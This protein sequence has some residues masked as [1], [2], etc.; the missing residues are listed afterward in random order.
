V[1]R[2]DTGA[3]GAAIGFSVALIG[4][5]NVWL[6]DGRG[7]AVPTAIGVAIGASALAALLRTAALAPSALLG[8][9]LFALCRFGLLDRARRPRSLRV[10]IAFAFGL[11]HGFGLTAPLA[12]LDLPSDRLAAALLGYNVGVA[13]GQLGWVVL[14]AATLYATTRWRGRRSTRTIVEIGSTA[15]FATGVFWFVRRAFG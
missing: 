11:V 13:I 7:R 6:I 12:A 5:E 9:G 14:L 2:P 10:A 15:L 3:V 4:A 8:L 1:L